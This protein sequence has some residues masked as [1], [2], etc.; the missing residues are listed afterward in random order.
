MGGFCQPMHDL[1]GEGGL[2]NSLGTT[3]IS[4]TDRESNSWETAQISTIA[5]IRRG[6]G[7][8][9]MLLYKQT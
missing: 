8:K 9:V 4:T 3:Q 5:L 1:R 7:D 2:F 6:E